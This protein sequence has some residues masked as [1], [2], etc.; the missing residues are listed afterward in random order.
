MS[1]KPAPAAPPVY[2]T[3]NLASS[4]QVRPF[5]IEDH[6]LIKLI[7]LGVLPKVLYLVLQSSFLIA[8]IALNWDFLTTE[9][10]GIAIFTVVILLAL[11]THT[12]YFLTGSVDPGYVQN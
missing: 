9:S 12:F 4:A 2:S 7:F 1:R 10:D 11:G 6:C 8:L 5:V 3:F